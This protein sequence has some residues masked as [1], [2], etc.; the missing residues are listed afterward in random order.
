MSE[1]NKNREKLIFN[2]LVLIAVSTGKALGKE[3]ASCSIFGAG[4]PSGQQWR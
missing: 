4:C 3:T 1:T 2:P